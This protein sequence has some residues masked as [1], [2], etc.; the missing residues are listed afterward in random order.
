MNLILLAASDHGISEVA[1]WVTYLFTALLA[2]MVLCLALEE[3]IH[4]KKSVIVGV[5]AVV[6]LLLGA[7]T[8]IMPFGEV[9]LPNGHKMNLPVFIP[10]IEWGVI[11][12]ILGSF[13]LSILVI[14]H[15]YLC[16]VLL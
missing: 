1:P 2:I 7:F 5:T 15:P 9:H 6:A 3:K 11:T 13:A 14:G 16:L 12:I 10:G 4:A 8:G